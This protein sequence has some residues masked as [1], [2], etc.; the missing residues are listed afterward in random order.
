MNINDT[1]WWLVI[2]LMAVYILF[3][4]LEATTN[5]VKKKELTTKSATVTD[6]PLPNDV[7]TLQ[8]SQNKS[9]YKNVCWNV[10]LVC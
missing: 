3:T 8:S 6:L 7:S 4:W 1:I 10:K 5:D 9:K 2:L